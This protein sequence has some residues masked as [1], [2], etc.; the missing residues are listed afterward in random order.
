MKNMINVTKSFMPPIEEYEKW[1]QKIW[2][3]RQLTNEGPILK[4]LVGKLK[5]YLGV[6]NINMLNNGTV[7]L[8]LALK[9]WE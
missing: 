7:A 8:E 5:D 6:E 1:I 9:A 3:N 4:E 2:E